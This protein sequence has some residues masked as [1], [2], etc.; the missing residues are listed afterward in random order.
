MN[1]AFLRGFIKA[2]MENGVHPLDI[3]KLASMGPALLGAIPGAIGGGYLAYDRASQRKQKEPT[4]MNPQTAGIAGALL[5]GGTG[6]LLGTAAGGLGYQQGTSDL[7]D[8]HL[9][10]FQ[11]LNEQYA[12]ANG[13]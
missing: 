9:K 12:S 7:N 6:G 11:A 2:A 8:V 5:G 4:A 1:P 3:P 10:L 13:S